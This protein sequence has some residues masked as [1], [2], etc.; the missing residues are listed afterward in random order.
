[1]LVMLLL[2]RIH[3]YAQTA[4]KDRWRR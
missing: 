2:A 1:L 4:E 3:H